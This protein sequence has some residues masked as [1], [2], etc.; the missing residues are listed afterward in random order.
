A[1]VYA[2]YLDAL[3]ARGWREPRE[4]ARVAARAVRE[5]GGLPPLVL[6]DGMQ[7]LRNGEVDLVSACAEGS[8]AWV[9]LDPAS[10]ERGAWTLAALR[11]A[12]PDA[13]EEAHAT[14]DATAPLE[15][16][17]AAD[18]EAQLREIAR[19]VKDRL[20][21]DRSLRP[22]DFAVVYRQVAPHLSLARRVFEE[23]R[24]PL[25]PAAGE[26]LAERPFGAWLLQLL[27]LGVHGWRTRDVFDA[28]AS[29][30]VGR[31]L[32]DGP[33]GEL[34]RLRRIARGSRL[35]VGLEALHSLPAST[36]RYL[37]ERDAEGQP[38]WEPERLRAAA[39]AWSGTTD[40]LAGTL[41]PSTE[42][43]PA[44]HAALLDAALFGPSGW[45]Q[46]EAEDY[47]T[48]G[49][50]TDA[51]RR[52][53]AGLRAVEAA[54][55]ATP[56]TFEAFVD[57]L[58]ARMQRPSTLIREAGGV[59]LAPMHT[60]HGLRFA[61]VY[62]GGLSEGEFPAQR[63]AGAL[64]DRGARDALRAAGL[65]LPP[66]PRASEQ[67]LWGTVTTRAGASTSLWRPRLDPAG[68]P[69]APS[70][71]FDAAGVAV[72]DVEAQ[73]SPER[74]ASP[75]ELAIALAGGW[76]A[77][78]RRPAG[79]RAWERV[80]R[81]A[82]PVEQRRRS[83]T[84][85]GA[86]EGAV[87]GVDVARFVD[88]EHRWSPTRLESYR[89][90]GFQFFAGSVL[91][92]AEVQEEQEQ[93]D[94]AT[95]GIVMHEMLDA[96]VAPVAARGAAL[97]RSTVEEV[98]AHLRGP[99]RA[100][101]DSAPERY[102]FGRA[103]LWRY[104]AA[105][106]LDQ[107]ESLVRREAERNEA[108]GITST[109]GGEE[110]F[111]AALPGVEPP[112]LVHGSVDRID[113]G[114]DLVQIVD[115]KTGAPIS[116]SDVRAGRRLQLQVYALASGERFQGSR[117]V[118][119]Y[120]FLRPGPDWSLDSAKDDDRR[121]LEDAA[122]VAAEVREHVFAGDFQVAPQVPKCPPYCDFIHACR[123]SPFSRSKTWS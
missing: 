11:S 26:R 88:A 53:L 84:S 122:A 63:P 116:A 45:L 90:C 59:L 105:A 6:V 99:G 61:H 93:A 22:S 50:E 33:A 95:R 41:D 114:P 97:D 118:A 54:L 110:A 4:T 70:Y 51:L 89:L 37:G 69:T 18:A 119:R 78:V 112:M 66:E 85:A 38:A 29:G 10:S 42:R 47:P 65:D 121:V 39:V 94:A 120:A 67:E 68:R 64:L 3:A 9:A 56:V 71:Y 60:L 7:F 24:L 43:T 28:L 52:E 73:T 32:S 27:R 40:A 25:D 14:A 82:A 106:A 74:A 48:L 49:V 104:E 34:G 44:D 30:F 20:T 86:Y 35:W 8:E 46:V 21:A 87:A 36:D 103:A 13:Q 113:R 19:S 2:G 31:G 81:V 72:T 55:G 76:P 115:Y 123:V 91:R 83:F 23:T 80:V 12:V 75:R 5:R 79:L 16:C 62:V 77:E 107:L 108:L 57:T 117:L 17:S 96:A 92:L 1:D 111:V 15:A 109:V 100:L 102:A 101:W 58:E 98:V